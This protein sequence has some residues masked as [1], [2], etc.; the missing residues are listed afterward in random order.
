MAERPSDSQRFLFWRTGVAAPLQKFESD[1][2]PR[3]LYVTVVV[4]GG[5]KERASSQ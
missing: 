1:P 4:N 2:E 3:F 5:V